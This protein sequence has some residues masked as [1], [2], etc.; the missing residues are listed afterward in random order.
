M[1]TQTLPNIGSSSGLLPDNTK[2]ITWTNV[3]L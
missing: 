1:V 3:N 2:A